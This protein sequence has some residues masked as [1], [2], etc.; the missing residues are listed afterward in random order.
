MQIDWKM[1]ELSA[2]PSS[3]AVWGIGL[4]RLDAETVGLNPA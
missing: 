3:R 1:R 4:D 2:G